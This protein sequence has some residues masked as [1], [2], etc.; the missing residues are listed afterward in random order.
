M[1]TYPRFCVGVGNSELGG[2]NGERGKKEGRESGWDRGWWF[3]LN[4]QERRQP[5]VEIQLAFQTDYTH[6]DVHRK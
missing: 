4:T 1:I 5:P 3:G 6:A 2:R